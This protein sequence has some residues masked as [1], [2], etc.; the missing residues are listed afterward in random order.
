M[1]YSNTQIQS[2]L[3]KVL[4]VGRVELNFN[5]TQAAKRSRFAFYRRRGNR[6]VRM[7]LIGKVLDLTSKE[8][9]NSYE[10]N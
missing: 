6:P 10:E 7:A 5:S 3:D 4:I 2:L 8:E 1:S 9:D